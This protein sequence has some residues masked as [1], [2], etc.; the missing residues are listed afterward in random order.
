MDKNVWKNQ[1][2]ILEV[3]YPK[4][5]KRCICFLTVCSI[6]LLLLIFCYHYPIYETFYGTI[7]EDNKNVVTV[8]VPFLKIEEFE[9]AIIRN[10]DVQ[11][12]SVDS[13]PEFISGEHVIKAEV[14]VSISK[15]L[16][17]ENNIVVIRVK[18]K[19]MSIWKEFSQKWKKGMK[20]EA[21]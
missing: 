2:W 15:K 8:M 10:R 3:P 19:N 5:I 16:L 21:N 20:N 11:L 12:V 17:V 7:N 6:L 1:F 14:I 13:T 18:T 9:S 4:G